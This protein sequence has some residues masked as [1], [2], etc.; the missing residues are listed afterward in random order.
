MSIAILCKLYE[1]VKA[2]AMITMSLLKYTDFD[3]FTLQLSI[4]LHINERSADF[5]WDHVY[6]AF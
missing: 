2:K 4:D 6:L 3:K 1:N 5:W